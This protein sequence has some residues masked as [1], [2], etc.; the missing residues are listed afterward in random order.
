MYAAHSTRPTSLDPETSTTAPITSTSTSTSKYEEYGYEDE[1][2]R[3][4]FN[5]DTRFSNYGTTINIYTFK[6]SFKLESTKN[7][8]AQSVRP[9]IKTYFDD[10]LMFNHEAGYNGE[11]R[12]IESMKIK[13]TFHS[14]SVV[15]F[16]KIKDYCN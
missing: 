11:W 13:R 9:G 1:D 2:A 16:N 6:T 8:A 10:V 5:S 3:V 4:I 12:Q 7:T 15:N 14:M